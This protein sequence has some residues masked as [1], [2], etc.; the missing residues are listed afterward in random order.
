MIKKKKS[1]FTLV[2]I[3]VVVAIIGIL[4][5]LATS[6]MLRSRITTNEAL[7]IA[8][9]KTI[10]SAC[11]G[12][13]G[14]VI[15]HSYPPNL[16]TLGLS[17]PGGPAYIDSDLSSGR[18]SGYNFI[19][20]LTSPVSFTLYADPQTPGRTGVRYFYCD[21]TGRITA[22]TGGRAGPGDPAVN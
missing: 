3:M 17:G 19:Y 4:A 15:P 1:G 7:A 22:K 8:S 21:E 14:A 10:T 6:M 20:I 11:Q 9:C 13:Y 18:R 16:R 5:T 2:E 12:Y